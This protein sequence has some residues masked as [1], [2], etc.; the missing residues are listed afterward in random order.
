MTEHLSTPLL[1]DRDTSEPGELRLVTPDQRGIWDAFVGSDPHGHL[2]QSWAWGELKDAFGWRTLR[3]ALWDAEGQHMLAGAQV[4]CRPLPVLPFSIAYI[5]KGPIIDWSDDALCRRFF[6]SLH[7]LLRARRIVFLR[8]DPDLPE[9]MSEIKGEDG[10]EPAESAS[11]ADTDLFGNLYSVAQGSLA[12]QRLRALGFR[13]VEES[14]QPRRTIAVD[15]TP[16]EKAISLR[17]RPKWRY[18]A[19]LAARKGVTVR[20][21]A[22]LAD[23]QRW[24]D[25]M[26][27]TSERDRFAVHTFAYYQRAWELMKAAGQ[28]ELFL[29]EHQDRLLAGI[30]VTQVGHEGIYLY[31]ASGNEG[32]NLMPNHLLQWEAMRW[33]KA[34]G[35]TLYDLWGVAETEDP[36]DPMAGVYRF[37]RG[38]GGKMVRYI[39]SFDYIYS[40]LLYRGFRQGMDFLK[41]REA[42]R[43]RRQKQAGEDRVDHHASGTASQ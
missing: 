17:Q 28:A 2:L 41:R 4:L 30:F 22:T 31:G 13:P 18:N 9:H 8:I 21:A 34:R 27:V 39:G 35:A 29:A 16:D 6:Q 25:L 10:E 19:G 23:L 1:K 43:L 15:L 14:I 12:A 38:W 5:P 33:C 3:V 37:K 26:Q 7:R 32:R 42:A 40:P 36:N 20:P 11:A 24:Y